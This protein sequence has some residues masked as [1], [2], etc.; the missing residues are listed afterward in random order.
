VTARGPE[1]VLVFHRAAFLVTAIAA[2]AAAAQQPEMLIHAADPV[3]DLM[4]QLPGFYEAAVRLPLAALLGGVLAFRPRRA[5]TPDR[6]A[7][8]I[9]TQILLAIVG[10]IVMIVVGQSLARAFGIVGVASLVRYRAK[11][12]DPKDA[13]V[14]LA[15][16]GIGL[17]CGVGIYLVAIFAT[18]FLIGFLWWVESLEPR[19]VQRFLLGVSAPNPE[20]LRKDVERLLSRHR[21]SFELR[22]L[23]ETEISYEV[24]LPYDQSTDK[25]SNA[26][27]AMNGGEVTAVQWEEKKDD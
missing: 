1:P 27:A 15:C 17:A 21:A 19:P 18:A 6:K 12:A 24:T 13:G 22:A 16:L 9:Q 3:P 8:V 2:S 5:G 20:G 14:M 26:I 10:A 25:I 4:G 11:I 7:V 23:S